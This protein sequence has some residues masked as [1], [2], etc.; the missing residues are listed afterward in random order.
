MVEALRRHGELNAPDWAVE[1][2][3]EMSPSTADRLLKEARRISELRGRSTTKPGSLHKNDI[4]IRLGT[5]WE[6]NKPGYMEMDLVAHCGETTAGDYVN[7]LDMT[8]IYSGWT[9]TAAVI[10]K[11]QVH[12]FAAIKAIRRLLPFALLGVDSDNGSEFIN[13][14]LYRYCIAENLVF[15][16]SRPYRKNDNCHVEQKN[17]SVVRKQIGYARLEGEEAV[18]TLNTYYG[19]LRR[20]S[21]FVRP[22]AKLLGKERRG[23]HIYKK[24]DVPLTP[25][26]RLLN[27]PD[28]TDEQKTVLNAQFISLNPAALKRGMIA[29]REQIEILAL[30]LARPLA[31]S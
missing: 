30:P 23:A 18:K 26:D 1:Q 5:E 22:S 14:H 17:Y 21:N 7:T 29:L 8:D 9:E 13:S 24:Y 31:T 4:P 10:N 25:F 20:Y 28:I 19:L 11:A 12:V 3:L 27:S 16:R 2:V 6:E 15:T